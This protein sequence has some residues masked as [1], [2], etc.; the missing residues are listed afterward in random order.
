MFDN[1]I[2]TSTALVLRLFL[3]QRRYVKIVANGSAGCCYRF[4]RTRYSVSRV[5]NSGLLVE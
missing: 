1:L 2:R 4:K 3:G 5:L